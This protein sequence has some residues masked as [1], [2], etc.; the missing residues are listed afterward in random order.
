MFNNPVSFFIKVYFERIFVTNF[1]QLTRFS[2]F[3][4]AVLSLSFHLLGGQSSSFN[5]DN[6]SSNSVGEV[7]T[8]SNVTF[9]VTSFKFKGFKSISSKGFAKMFIRVYW[10]T[11]TIR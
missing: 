1:R 6:N 8:D 5:I 3:T 9:K 4:L 7:N 2:L 11:F 10:A